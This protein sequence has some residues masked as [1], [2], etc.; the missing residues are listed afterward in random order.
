MSD[1]ETITI[2]GPKPRPDNTRLTGWGYSSAPESK[3]EI[4]QSV[5]SPK[6]L[7]QAYALTEK[8]ARNNMERYKAYAKSGLHDDPEFVADME[9]E[10]KI[11]HFAL[12]SIQ[13]IK[14]EKGHKLDTPYYP[15]PD[16]RPKFP[17]LYEVPEI[18]GP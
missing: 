16:I 10:A 15:H 4:V 9:T 8:M 2:V 3:G 13:G 7:S 12:S 6:N 5:R 17:P 1:K 11:M 18:K 14:I